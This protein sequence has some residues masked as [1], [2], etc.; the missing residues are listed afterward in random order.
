MRDRLGIL[1]KSKNWNCD[2]GL[3]VSA[4]ETLV[5]QTLGTGGVKQQADEPLVEKRIRGKYWERREGKSSSSDI[6]RGFFARKE[7]ASVIKEKACTMTKSVKLRLSTEN[8]EEEE[9][10]LEVS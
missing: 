6:R 7:P 2:A 3:F 4:A 5:R 10:V 8:M 1:G 9:E